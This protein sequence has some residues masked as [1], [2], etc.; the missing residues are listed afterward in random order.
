[1]DRRDLLP[2]DL[3]S[4]Y[5]N[6]RRLD[7]GLGDFARQNYSRVNPFAENVIG[8]HEKA[9][10][11]FGDDSI[12]IYDSATVIG[13]VSVG[14]HSWI[15]PFCI[16]DGSGGL[17]IGSHCSVSAGVM[18]FSHDTVLWSLSGGRE[19]YEHEATAIGDDC[20]I[21]TQSVILKGT[22]IGNTC[23]VGANS[24]VN[25]DLPANSIA[26]GVPARI[27]GEVVRDGD[28]VVLDYHRTHL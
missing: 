8:W 15:G 3:K 13:D 7:I 9:E 4:L 10:R 1:M 23:L 5:D 20:F 25:K 11:C 21:G 14:P 2:D 19:A 12:T 28:G 6:L 26:V 22:H 18:V 24:L 16:L 17:T 27:I